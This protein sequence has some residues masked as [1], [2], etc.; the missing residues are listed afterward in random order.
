MSVVFGIANVFQGQAAYKQDSEDVK[1]EGDK[2]S[3]P[4]SGCA[5]NRTC[6]CPRILKWGTR[7]IGVVS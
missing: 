4:V 1:V 7:T 6:K 5:G 2:K 3:R